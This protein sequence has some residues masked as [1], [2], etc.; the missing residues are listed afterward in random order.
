MNHSGNFFNDFAGQFD[1]FYD[2]KRSKM[3]QWIDHLFRKDMFIRFEMTFELMDHL[4]GKSILDIGCGSGPYISEALRRGAAHVTGIDPALSMLD[5]A[6]ER[7]NRMGVTERASLIQGYFPQ[8]RPEGNFDFAIVMGVT[9]YIEDVG[10]F[11]KELR[12]IVTQ[13]AVV[14]FPSINW[15]RTPFRKLRYKIRKCPVYFYS[16]KSIMDL[17]ENAG[18]RNYKI[19]K[20]RGAGLD[21]ILWFEI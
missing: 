14:S 21:F 10:P 9:D 12:N 2:G 11:M 1:T 4:N 7:L 16:E 13:R 17:V 3:M 19:I 18:I 5:L 6:R 8:V 20:I 15:F